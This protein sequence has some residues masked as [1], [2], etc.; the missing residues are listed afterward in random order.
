PIIGYENSIIVHSSSILEMILF[1]SWENNKLDFR[2]LDGAYLSTSF[3]VKMDG[4]INLQV[5]SLALGMV[6]AQVYIGHPEEITLKAII[7]HGKP[8]QL[9]ITG[10]AL[11]SGHI[12]CF[13]KDVCSYSASII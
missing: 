5:G 4:N 7:N 12:K 8:I 13:G 1:G 3:K 2:I 10:N 9:D 11:F 6:G